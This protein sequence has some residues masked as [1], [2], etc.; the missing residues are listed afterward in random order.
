M[1]R[2]R[3]SKDGQQKYLREADWTLEQNRSGP[4]SD[5]PFSSHVTQ[6]KFPLFT[7][8]VCGQ[9]YRP[10]QGGLNDINKALR[11]SDI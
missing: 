8:L 7:E 5:L 4:E 10:A 9:T 2:I 11:C 6:D 3:N 1:A